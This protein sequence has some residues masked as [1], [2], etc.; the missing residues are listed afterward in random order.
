M[1]FSS[2]GN[3]AE[4]FGLHYNDLIFCAAAVNGTRGG[5]YPTVFQRKL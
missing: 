4:V 2:K 3:E 5:F 1:R